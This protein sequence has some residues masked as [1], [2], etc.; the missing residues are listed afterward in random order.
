MS[1]ETGVDQ[2]P[3]HEEELTNRI[4]KLEKNCLNRTQPEN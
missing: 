3:F 2:Q 4:G 1:I